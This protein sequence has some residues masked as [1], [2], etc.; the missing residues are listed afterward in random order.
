MMRPQLSITFSASRAARP[1]RMRGVRA[2]ARGFTL[3]EMLTAMA[4]FF[5]VSGILA[6]GV[7]QAIRV[8]ERGGVE[9]TNARNQSMR[10]AWFREAIGLTMLP[11]N[12]IRV[13][14][15]PL[16]LVGDVRSVTGLSLQA[17]RAQSH[18]PGRYRFEIVFDATRGE[19][20]LTMTNP[21]NTNDTA[22]QSRIELASWRGS[23]GRFRYLDD[24][25]RWQDVWPA[26]PSAPKDYSRSQLPKA[27]ELRYGDASGLTS[28]SI[29]VAIQDR[30]L[31]LPTMRELAQ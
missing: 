8:A 27:V 23:E 6:S 17:F 1:L 31:P 29:I 10:L 24:D 11:P 18:A 21:T 26:D 5:M 15:T 16:P 7:S 4:L 28:Q 2:R 20:L 3:L 25:D 12:D 13:A 14:V 19:S 9:T 22:A 30:A